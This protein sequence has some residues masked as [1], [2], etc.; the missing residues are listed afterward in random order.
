MKQTFF[1]IIAALLIAVPHLWGEELVPAF[2]KTPPKIDG[3]LSDQAWQ[4]LGRE[5]TF[6]GYTPS[7]G[8]PFPRKTI[9]YTAYDQKNLYFAF[10]CE[11]PDPS[12]L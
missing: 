1:L 4:G 2:V 12:Q 6:V 5:L 7:L 11:D 8:S 10:L 9:V 3:D